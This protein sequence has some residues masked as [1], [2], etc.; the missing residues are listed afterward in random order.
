MAVRGRQQSDDKDSAFLDRVALSC[1]ISGT[2]E[3]TYCE[4]GPLLRIDNHLINTSGRM[5]F[6]LCHEI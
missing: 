4:D 1:C 2:I 5:S 3:F 6:C